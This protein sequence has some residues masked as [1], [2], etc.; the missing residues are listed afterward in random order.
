MASKKK[1]SKK[2]IVKVKE[3]RKV[4]LRAYDITQRTHE[5]RAVLST[6]AAMWGTLKILKQLNSAREEQQWNPRVHEIMTK[7][8]EFLEKTYQRERQ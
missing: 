1:K 5:R 3:E 4:P 6:D 2:K 7:D 8:L